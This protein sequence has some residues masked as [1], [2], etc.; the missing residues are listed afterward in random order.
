MVSVYKSSPL[1]RFQVYLESLAIFSFQLHLISS[2]QL[3]LET[4]WLSRSKQVSKSSNKLPSS[5]TLFSLAHCID[6]G[7]GTYSPH[8]TNNE[9]Q[10]DE[11]PVSS[12]IHVPALGPLSHYAGEIY[13]G[14]TLKTHLMFYVHTAREEFINVTITGH[15]GFLLE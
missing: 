1:F 12:T 3:Y 15:F 7:N 10:T 5:P 14:F 13:D 11:R 6:S 9:L 4:E 2:A 8:Q